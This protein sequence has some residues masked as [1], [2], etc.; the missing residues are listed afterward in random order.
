MSPMTESLPDYL[1]SFVTEQDYEAYTARDHAAWRFIMLQNTAFFSKHA[2]PIYGEGLKQT[3]IPLDRIPRITEMDDCLAKLGWGAVAVEGFIPPAAF[4]DFQARG[5]LPIAS[6]MRS[7]NHIAYTPAPDIVHEAAGHAPILADA[8]YAQY[9]HRYAAMA[10]KAIFSQDDIRLYEAIRYL[11]D[12]KENPDATAAMIADAEAKLKI[13]SQ[14]ISHLS[15]A[16]KVARMNWWTVE[17]GLMGNME[18]P[19]IFGAGLLSSVGESQTCLSDAVRKVPLTVRCVDTAY[20]ITE[21]Q[22]QLFVAKDV[23]HL[24]QVL[25]EFEHTLGYVKGGVSALEN[26][27][28][29]GAVTTSQLETG[30]QISGKLAEVLTSGTEVDFVRFDGPVQLAFDGKE[31]P[32]QGTVQHPQGF[33][34]PVGK[35]KGV[36]QSPL[37]ELSDAQ[38]KALGIEKGKRTM[39]RF[40]NGFTVDGTP[41]SWHRI[42]GRLVLI[43]WADCT[44]Q[45]ANQVTFKPEWGEFDMAVGEK[46]VSVFGGPADR[47]AYGAMNVGK[48]STSPA[49][50]SPFTHQE[51]ELFDTYAR[52]RSFR[53]NQANLGV[54]AF[55]RLAEHVLS[56]HANEWLIQ[57]ELLELA[58]P[59]S[60]WNERLIKNL[61]RMEKMLSGEEG[62]LI[63]K[64]IALAKHRDS[65]AA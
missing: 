21:P 15:E 10:Q 6:D 30:L 50:T 61:E 26:A 34:S 31:I 18:A 42:H 44:V 33:S 8:A 24:V 3:G 58:E 55:E 28:L 19:L 16:A 54:S 7:V 13:A 57:I 25:Q 43:R 9:L 51:L 60:R 27:R 37:S 4:L 35:W 32:G 11:S 56:D 39:L 29:S 40:E 47:M 46:A 23:D 59:S 36:H 5:V 20:N 22:P 17:Y 63:R 52:L 45:R 1:K 62:G 2:V 14:S 49:R 38:L 48:A 41:L 64:G 12:I 53:E 65:S